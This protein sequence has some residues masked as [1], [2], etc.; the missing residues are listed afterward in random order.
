[1]ND[2]AQQ[3]GAVD[4]DVLSRLHEG[5]GGGGF[6]EYYEEAGYVFAV[7]ATLPHELWSGVFYS[8]LSMKGHLQALHDF[9]RAELLASESD[10]VV[11][12]L[13]LV[14]WEHPEALEEWLTGGYP[15]DEMLLAVGLDESQIEVELMRDFA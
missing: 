10:G 4:S 7:R 8:W 6:K 15:I 5:L 3:R 1:M 2:A 12:A 13:F 14:V 11:E 9:M